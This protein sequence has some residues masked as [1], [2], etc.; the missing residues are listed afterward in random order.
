[1]RVESAVGDY[2]SV[3]QH[4]QKLISDVKNRGKV[5]LNSAVNIESCVAED[6]MQ[7]DVAIFRSC[8][9]AV[10]QISVVEHRTISAVE[11]EDVRNQ[12]NSRTLSAV[13]KKR[14]YQMLM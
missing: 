8:E 11:T 9:A 14:K 3:V 7:A 4:M 1:M 12:L 10:E 2:K 13:A 6:K 5:K